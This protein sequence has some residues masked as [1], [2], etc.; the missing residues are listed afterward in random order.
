M[1]VVYH[2]DMVHTSLVPDPSG[3]RVQSGHKTDLEGALGTRLARSCNQSP[4]GWL[5]E[6]HP[7]IPNNRC[8]LFLSTSHVIPIAMNSS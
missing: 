6:I 8:N 7:L 4:G 5:L 1:P 2:K 3:K